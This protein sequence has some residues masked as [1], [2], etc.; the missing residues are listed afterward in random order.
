[1][2][3]SESLDS[4]PK[5]PLQPWS[6]SLAAGGAF[7]QACAKCPGR[8]CSAS[9]T[10][11][12]PG[13]PA[14]TP[15]S[16]RLPQATCPAHSGCVPGLARWEETLPPA[17]GLD[18]GTGRPG[19]AGHPSRPT[20]PQ[21]YGWPLK[22]QWLWHAGSAVSEPVDW[23]EGWGGAL[24]QGL[25]LREMVLGCRAPGPRMPW[26]QEGQSIWGG[27]ARGRPG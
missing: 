10:L 21:G 15:P 22:G 5:G 2:C 27:G 16:L 17:V 23:R 11:A 9:G 1:M 8:T 3:R 12:A 4:P 25:R 24:R 26:L 20:H 6:H 13:G 14:P 19:T 7:R 18:S